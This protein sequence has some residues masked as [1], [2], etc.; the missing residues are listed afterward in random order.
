[1]SV[2]HPD[3]SASTYAP[4]KLPPKKRPPLLNYALPATA[5][6]SGVLLGL[7]IPNIINANDIV[8]Y[9]KAAALGFGGM[10]VSY[11]V[12][13]TAV[14]RGAPLGT[15]GYHGATVVSV[16]SILTV[17]GG[18]F[19]ATYSGLTLK[20]TAELQLQEHGQ[21]LAAYVG[22]RSE[23]AA[24]AARVLPAIRAIDA[25]LRQKAACEIATSC[26]S[27]RGNGGNGP[28][29]RAVGEHAGR[30]SSIGQQIEAGDAARH[31]TIGRLGA[32]SAEYQVILSDDEKDVWQRRAK[33]QVVDSR[34]RQTIG[35]LNEAVPLSLISA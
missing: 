34:I 16:L 3:A 27:G 30:A 9:A 28:V 33:L 25:D 29:A 19:A 2:L 14:D 31:E 5:L 6:G 10:A 15:I 13:K 35:E 8:D 7:A 23:A 12:N 17:G 4:I 32:M 1:M 20:D 22:Q 26:I 24:E 21:A 11:A 18:L